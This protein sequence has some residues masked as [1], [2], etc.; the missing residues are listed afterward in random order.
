MTAASDACV[1]GVTWMST[2]NRVGSERSNLTRM[3]SP[4][5]VAIEQCGIV[6]V[7]QMCTRP[8]VVDGDQPALRHVELLERVRVLRVLDAADQLEDLERVDRVARR[9]VV[10]ARALGGG[11]H[12]RLHRVHLGRGV[13]EAH[14]IAR[15]LR[16]RS[17]DRGKSLASSSRS[18]RTR[19]RG[20]SLR[21]SGVSKQLSIVH[22]RRDAAEQGLPACG[23]SG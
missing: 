23:D 14:R 16:Q 19:S 22:A 1:P 6:G 8:R 15:G 3:H 12:L 20:R 18:H 11:P 2:L 9:G 21:R 5:S 4:I 13:V 17:R 7:K 10:L